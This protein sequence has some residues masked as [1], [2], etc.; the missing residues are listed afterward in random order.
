MSSTENEAPAFHTIKLTLSLAC[1]LGLP[2]ALR[3]LSNLAREF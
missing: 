3:Y 1:R 2:W